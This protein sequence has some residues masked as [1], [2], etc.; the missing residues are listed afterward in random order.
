MRNLKPLS[1]F[2]FFALACE[3]SPKHI[4]LKVNVLKAREM[5]C[6]QVRPCI[7]L[8]GNFTCRGSERVKQPKRRVKT[9]AL[10][11]LLLKDATVGKKTNT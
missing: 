5:Y 4:A 6:L 1:L 2:V 11:L 9:A 7:S 8:P 3:N 10:L